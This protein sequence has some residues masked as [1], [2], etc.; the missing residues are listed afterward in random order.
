MAIHII[1]LYYILMQSLLYLLISFRQCIFDIAATGKLSVGAA[2][3]AATAE[4]T[5]TRDL[6]S[7]TSVYNLQ[8]LYL[9]NSGD[10]YFKK[11]RSCR[12]RL[13]IGI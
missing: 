3:Q 5:A 4:L 11:K 6:L 2:T 7:M 13:R 9:T 10:K 12:P 1:A 8:N